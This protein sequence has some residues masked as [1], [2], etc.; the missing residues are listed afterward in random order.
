MAAAARQ[1]DQI[2]LWAHEMFEEAYGF[3]WGVIHWLT[4]IGLWCAVEQI[5]QDVLV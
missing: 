2:K 3:V 5:L 4:L 1:S